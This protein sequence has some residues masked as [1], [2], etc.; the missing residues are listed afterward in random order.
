[1][2]KDAFVGAL[3]SREEVATSRESRRL[4]R[5]V[6]RRHVHT[7]WQVHTPW[8]HNHGYRPGNSPS[9]CGLIYSP[10]WP[11]C[12]Q[13]QHPP[14]D[15]GGAMPTHALGPLT[16][17][18]AVDPEGDHDLTLAPHSLSLERIVS[19]HVPRSRPTNFSLTGS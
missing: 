6:L 8:F 1:M 11:Q 14:K 15:R 18:P 3:G 9:P 19:L 4:R 12:C 17:V 16:S 2:D 7:C 13:Q 5:A 10:V